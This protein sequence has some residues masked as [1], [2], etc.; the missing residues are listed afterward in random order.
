MRCQFDDVGLNVFHNKFVPIT[1]I[2]IIETISLVS[3]LRNIR[4]I[5]APMI[6]MSAFNKI[7]IQTTSYHVSA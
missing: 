6:T 2:Y 1:Y 7:A 3:H 4:V 5:H